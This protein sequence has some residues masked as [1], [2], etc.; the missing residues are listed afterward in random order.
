MGKVTRHLHERSDPC[1]RNE[2]S[3]TDTAVARGR[4]TTRV[5]AC[6]TRCS[7]AMAPR[8]LRRPRL[9]ACETARSGSCV[10]DRVLC[11]RRARG[12]TGQYARRW[13]MAVARARPHAPRAAAGAAR[14]SHSGPQHGAA[15]TS[16]RTRPFALGPREHDGARG[17]RARRHWG[18]ESGG[19]G[20]DTFDAALPARTEAAECR[21]EWP[22]P[23][24]RKPSKGLYVDTEAVTACGP[25][26][27]DRLSRVCPGSSLVLPARWPRG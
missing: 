18:R 1:F 6:A 2:T 15:P 16:G 22:R 3:D 23:G 4:R 5:S 25:T 7:S 24:Q 21:A 13:C 9:S 26:C 27:P 17:E 11:W 8:G 10:P 20:R 12:A 14:C 19:G